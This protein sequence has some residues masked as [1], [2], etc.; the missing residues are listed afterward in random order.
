MRSRTHGSRDGHGHRRSMTETEG[1]FRHGH[2]LKGNET[3]CDIK[4]VDAPTHPQ[5]FLAYR[6]L[7]GCAVPERI[8][9]VGRGT[10]QRGDTRRLLRQPATLLSDDCEHPRTDSGLPRE[11]IQPAM[12]NGGF[13]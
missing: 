1:V 5:R 11:D 10:L 9:G 7:P 8:C 2:C 4:D 3:D 13:V 6:D 12:R